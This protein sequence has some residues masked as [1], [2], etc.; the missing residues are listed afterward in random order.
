MSDYGL[1]PLGFFPKKGDVILPEINDQTRAIFGEN[2]NLNPESPDGQINGILSEMIV[3]NWLLSQAVYQAFDPEAAQGIALQRLVLLNGLRVQQATYS[4]VTA[5]FTGRPST[6]IPAGFQVQALNNGPVFQT[7][8]DATITVFDTIDVAM[9]SVSTGPIQANAGQLTQLVT[10][11]IGVA[12]VNNTLAAL[13]GRDQ[14]DDVSLRIRRANSTEFSSTNIMD[15]LYSKLFAI[16]NVFAIRIYE[17]ETSST[18]FRGLPPHSFNV[19]IVGGDDQ[20][21]ANAIWLTKPSGILPFGATAKTVLDSQGIAHQISFDR[22]TPV[23]IYIIINTNK[24]ATLFPVDGPTQIKNNIV[25]YAIKNLSIGDTVQR[26]RLSG[27]ANLVPGHSIQRIFIGL[28]P[29]PTG[30]ADILLA[31]NQIANITA[32]NITVNVT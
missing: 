13:P 32:I 4:T 17:N 29:A 22:P 12:S 28:S 27:P 20:T 14:E 2:I 18:D 1:T 3:N 5:T 16:L 7:L 9:Q 8:A 21:I 6:I 30:T 24:D 31:F 19:I 25:N 23:T 15:S 11:I 26:V 10:P